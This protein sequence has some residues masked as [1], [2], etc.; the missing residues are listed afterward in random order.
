MKQKVKIGLFMLLFMF[1]LLAAENY[2]QKINRR[3]DLTA[4]GTID[5]SNINGKIEITTRSTG[6]VEVLAVKK[7]DNKGEIETVDVIF[8]AGSNS[9]RIRTK[10]NKKNTRAKV[11]FTIVVPE[12]LSRAAFKSVNGALDCRGKFAELH[13]KTVNG[14]IKFS[15]DF[16]SAS[17]STVNGSVDISQEA[18]LQGDLDVETVNG[19]ID[20]EINRK[21]AFSV[22]GSTVNGGITNDFDLHVTKH[23]VGSSLDGQV[24]GGG[25]KLNLETVNGRIS[26]AKI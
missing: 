19:G 24:N 5:L 10:F 6:A 3:F 1:S 13:L 26:I 2:E 9:V 21:S 15:G 22:E 12:K 7:S 8:E 14:R 25:H 11:D 18:Q 23:F 17:L 16:N 20:I 4:D